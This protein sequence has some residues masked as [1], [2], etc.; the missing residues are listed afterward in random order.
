MVTLIVVLGMTELLSTIFRQTNY[1]N[2]YQ[3]N[4]HQICRDGK[5]LA[6]NKQSGII[7][8]DPSRDAAVATNF[9]GEIDGESAPL[10]TTVCRKLFLK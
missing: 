6:V 4:F 9:V 10:G 7:F 5:T 3:T 1:L 8:F 2:I